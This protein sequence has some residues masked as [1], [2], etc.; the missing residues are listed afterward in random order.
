MDAHTFALLA[1]F[2]VP[3][4]GVALLFVGHWLLP[5]G[6]WSSFPVQTLVTGYFLAVA[7]T[8]FLVIYKDAQGEYFEDPAALVIEAFALPPGT[9]V[10][11]QRDR[12]VRLGDCWRSAVNWRSSVEFASPADFDQWAKSDDYKAAILNQLAA[13]HGLD[14][15]EIEVQ[16]GALDLRERDPKY[17]L[18]EERGSYQ[19]NVRI[20]EFYRPFVCAAIERD[21]VGRLSLRPCDPVSLQHDTGNAGRVILNPNAKNRDGQ[22]EG[23]I[24]YAGGPHYCTNPVRRA[25]NDALGLDH[26]E[27]DT[28]NTNMASILPL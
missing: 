16:P 19:Q 9:K 15:G 10:N 23:R 6:L 17:E 28:P 4:L 13:Y 12:T 22:L 11:H 8:P 18:S 24:Y 1:V 20:I 3:V 2:G 26:P 7:A 27:H 21:E 5:K 14:A 25:V